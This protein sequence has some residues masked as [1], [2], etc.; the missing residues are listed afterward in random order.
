MGD[1]VL[2]I[3]G[4]MI[5]YSGDD[6]NKF[7]WMVRIAEGEHPQD[8]KES[9][10]FTPNGEY[11]VDEQAP[12]I[13]TD[14]VM[15][16]CSYYRFGELMND[17]RAPGGYDRTRNSEVGVHNIKLK[18]LEEAYTSENWLVRIYRVKKEANRSSKPKLGN[19]NKFASKKTTKKRA[20]TLRPYHQDRIAPKN[21][22][23]ETKPAR[24]LSDNS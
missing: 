6:I 23:V 8:I 4:A 1:Y 16:K 15:Y 18:Y 19:R 2:V 14:S 21:N 13:F 22:G 5:G 3:F 12:K 17:P 9:N 10:Y 7:L 24:K 20:G 11:R